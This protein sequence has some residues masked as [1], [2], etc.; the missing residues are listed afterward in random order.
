[1]K[2]KF[3]PWDR[4]RYTQ[5]YIEETERAIGRHFHRR[6]YEYTIIEQVLDKVYLCEC[7]ELEDLSLINTLLCEKIED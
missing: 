1:M 4:V 5:E 6:D 2:S 7:K 3:K